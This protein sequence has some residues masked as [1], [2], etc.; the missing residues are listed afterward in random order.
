MAEQAPTGEQTAGLRVEVAQAIRERHESLAADLEPVL[1]ATLGGTPDAG[2]VAAG[3]ALLVELIASTVEGRRLDPRGGK[4]VDLQQLF[5]EP[6][7]VRTLF[8][9]IDRAERIVIDELA[10]HE[11]LG[12]TSE[13]WAIV[14]QVVRLAALDVQIAVTERLIF[15]PSGGVVLDPLT[16]LT[17]RPVFDLA[18][19]KEVDRAQRRGHAIA[20]IL[21]DIDQLSA[22]N[23]E[24][25]YGSGDRLLERLGILARRFFRHED[26]LARHGEDSLAALLPETSLDD[27][28]AL[29]ER[30]RRMVR[31]RMVLVDHRTDV[32]VRVTVSTAVVGTDRLISH[33]DPK[34]F[35]A[36]AEVA[37]LRAKL[38][39]PDHIEHVALQ[40]ASVTIL[41]A[42]NLLD[43]TPRDV[44]RM[45]RTGELAVSK[46]GRHYHIDR[47]SI[48]RHRAKRTQPM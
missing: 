45:I 32:L 33:I 20:L 14:N 43:C 25:G 8:E 22:I 12:A 6:L 23:R 11:N 2:A 24:L 18:L 38:N 48:E 36:E 34:A 19:A 7:S 17:A 3:A 26:W 27:A 44:R 42:A 9:S 21:F 47:V 13:P 1:R 46:R 39:G 5:P 10:L 37:L 16:T 35:L 29:A 41:G 31:Q 30:F 4:V 28:S 40:P 15:S